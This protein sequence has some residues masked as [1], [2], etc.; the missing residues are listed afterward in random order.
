MSK[1]SRKHREHGNEFYKS[2][3]EDGLLPG[4]KK[5]RLGRAV[6]HYLKAV[7]TAKSDQD[8]L[9]SAYKNYAKASW[10][11]AITSQENYQE[12]GYFYNIAFV[13]FSKSLSAGEKCKEKSWINGL[14]DSLT[15][16]YEEAIIWGYSLDSK[17][18]VKVFQSFVQSLEVTKFRADIWLEIGIVY[19][20]DA[21][22]ALSKKDF[23]RS[24][25]SLKELNRP[26]EEVKSHGSKQ[27]KNKVEEMELDFNYQMALTESL[28]SICSGDDLLLDHLNDEENVNMDLIYT[29]VDFYRQA[30][31]LAR[32]LEIEVEAIAWSRLGRLYDQVLK[33]K[34]RATKAFERC[35]QL[36]HSLFPRALTTEPWFK[37]ATETLQRYQ[38]ESMAEQDAALER[39]RQKYLQELTEEMKKLNEAKEDMSS[40]DLLPFIYKEFPLKTKPENFSLLT[41]E[42]VD[43][44]TRPAKKKA[45]Q[46]AVV[47]YHPDKVDVEKY[48]MK[49]K[50]LCGEIT[51]ILTGVYETYKA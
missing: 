11:M 45:F 22:I 47:Y 41:K 26:M 5:F 2:A 50:V 14:L 27:L 44:M 18:R 20:H 37:I 15:Q 31:I 9:A 35:L 10:G 28:Q 48:G 38:K 19:L 4:V 13:Q 33:V 46:K 16:M 23:K 12:C 25:H 42:E 6:N 39:T 1:Q 32:E 3:L 34:Y 40:E 17:A 24:L 30:I 36:A 21:V 49:W 29:V 51:K 8:A 7:D 43:K